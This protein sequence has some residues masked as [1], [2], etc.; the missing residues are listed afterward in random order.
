MT[1]N[2][3]HLADSAQAP[4]KA[5]LKGMLLDVGVIL[6]QD[7]P[8]AAPVID[9]ALRKGEVGLLVGGTKT[10]KTWAIIHL[11]TAMATGGSWLG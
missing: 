1:A 6:R 10:S 7:R 3:L 8:L 2:H 9:G 4:P 5:S 11:H